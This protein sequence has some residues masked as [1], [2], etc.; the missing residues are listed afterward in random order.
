M[1][2][3]VLLLRNKLESS[4]RKLEDLRSKDADFEKRE[5]ELE[6]A[7]NEMT[8]E[9]SEE[10]KKIIEEN[11]D[12]FNSEKNE[13]EKEKSG[14]EEEIK[15]I[16]NEIEEEERKQSQAIK[17]PEERKENV[18]N[19][20]N[21][22]KFFGMSYQERDVFFGREDIRGFLN[23]IRTCMKEQRALTNVGIT[24]PTVTLPLIRQAAAEYSKLLRYVTVRAVSGT[25]RQNIMGEIPEAYWDE[26]C[27][28]IKEMD[29]AFYN[30]EIEGYKVSGYFE[31]CNSTLEDSDVDLMTE[32]IYAIGKAIAKAIDK[33]ILYG[34]GVK[35]ITGIVTSILKVEAPEGYPVTGR[36]WEDLSTSHVITGTQATGI[37]LFQEIVKNSGV[38]ENDYESGE[39]TW[40]MNKKTHTKIMSES[41][42]VNQAAAVVAG[43]GNTMPVVGGDIVEFKFIP[44][45]TIIFGYFGSYLLVERA[46][47]VISQSEHVKF[48]QD[49]TVFKGTA[50]YDGKPVIREA[51]GIMGIGKAPVTTAPKFAGEE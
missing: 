2:L 25:S 17:K 9:T 41:I 7:I 11:I 38:V 47:T 36:P 30:T 22:T 46:S 19:M 15:R 23:E 45:D 6:D 35:M 8:E 40:V 16:E 43:M 33:G 39:I 28:A 29:L 27:A 44:D 31:V 37:K 21:R 42:G 18:R 20:E 4:R 13:H 50:R 26:M 12:S 14:L 49:N 51:F 1:A 34:K 32:L 5:S 3:K 48:I 10:D 24:I